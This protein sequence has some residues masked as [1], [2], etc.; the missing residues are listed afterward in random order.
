M[1]KRTQKIMPFAC[2][3]VFL[4]ALL[5]NTVTSY[6]RQGNPPP[7][8]PV[9]ESAEA[10]KVA[11]WVKDLPPATADEN[12]FSVIGALSTMNMG[13]PTLQ[14]IRENGVAALYADPNQMQTAQQTVQGWGERMLEPLAAGGVTYLRDV[15]N[16]PWGMV[17]YE[18]GVTDYTIIDTLVQTA[19]SYNMHYIGTVMP[20]ANWDLVGRPIS[21]SEMCVRLLSQDYFYVAQGG[22]LDRYQNLD[23]FITWLGQ[24]VERYDGDGVDDMP[25]LKFGVHY[26]QIHNEPEGD[27]CGLYRA[28]PAE[29]VLLMQRGYAA[30]KAACPAC[31][32]INGGAGFKMWDEGRGVAGADFWPTY[33]E[34]GGAA[35]VDVVAIHYNAGKGDGGT[36]ENLAYQATRIRELLG[37]DKPMWATEFGTLIRNADSPQ[38]NAMNFTL[39]TETEA[40]A[41]YIRFYTIG[42][43]NGV[44]RFFSDAPSF[45]EPRQ[46][47]ILLPYY[48][49]KLLQ[50]KLGGFTD[51][52]LLAAGQY[53]F[54]V[55]GRPVY[56]VWS[57]IPT[58]LSGTVRATDMYGNEQSADVATLQPSTAAPLILELN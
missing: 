43:A 44:T 54:T 45:I 14:Y 38:N 33:A 36:A 1:Q 2:L 27:Q 51:A 31:Q 23:A 24:T 58:E 6:A 12:Y 55:N 52:T 17:E 56:V 3:I 34:L 42:L 25:G 57:G 13:A 19:E 21:T 35:Y 40:A 29:F 20:F 22:V 26:W 28:D 8:P 53:R 10:A 46:R 49:N 32:V 30:V 18:Q 50:A 16:I 4:A 37:H 39:L 7:P 41:W 48:I 47:Q 15:Q 11:Q 5:S 9:T